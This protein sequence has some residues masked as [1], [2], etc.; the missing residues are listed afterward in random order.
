MGPNE[1]MARWHSLAEGQPFDRAMGNVEQRSRGIVA[2]VKRLF[3]DEV[4]ET[5]KAVDRRGSRDVRVIDSVVDHA[6]GMWMNLLRLSKAVS[7]S[8]IHDEPFAVVSR[9]PA[10]NFGMPR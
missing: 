4:D 8:S 2:I 5:L 3:G 9:R 10:R 7:C 1:V 6:S